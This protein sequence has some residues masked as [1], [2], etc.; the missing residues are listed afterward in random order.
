ME[1]AR[2]T[3]PGSGELDKGILKLYNNVVEQGGTGQVN[4][5]TAAHDLRFLLVEFGLSGEK[6][7]GD[8]ERRRPE[9]G[10]LEPKPFANAHFLQ[11][12]NFFI[13]TVIMGPGY[14][15]TNPS[16]FETSS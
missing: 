5:L 12:P 4:P 16:F 6:P 8:L 14:L 15:G 11:T 10:R 1:A 2:V 13:E 7:L 3:R 9:D